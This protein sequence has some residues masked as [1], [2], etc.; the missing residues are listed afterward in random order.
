MLSPLSARKAEKLGYKN[1]K[2]FHAGLPA[3]KKAGNLVVSNGSAIENYDK[4]DVSYILLDLR[5]ANLVEKSH[6][7]KAVAV[8]AQ[9]I[10][11]LN[12]Q[13]PAYKGA[14]II[15]YNQDGN[16]ATAQDT[17]KKITGWGYN[18]V[19]ILNGGFQGWEKAAKQ[20]AKGPAATK[21]TYVRK[22]APGEFEVAKFR[23]LV[24]KPTKDM[25]ILDVR[26]PSEVADG[27]FAD[28]LHIPMDEL[29]QRLSEVPKDKPVVL[30]CVTG[31]RAE[32]AYEVLKKAGIDAKWVKAKIGFDKANKGK[33]T[34]EE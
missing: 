34:I 25:V 12:G 23:E 14:P 24:E 5:P 7:L 1:I 13:L 19:S 2:V 11:S 15:L 20:V 10:D 4:Q 29:E 27:K 33:Y 21:I 6:I 26:L 31:A 30:H 18:Q 32:M 17:F 28:S 3:W 9:E 22:L 16:L 8:P